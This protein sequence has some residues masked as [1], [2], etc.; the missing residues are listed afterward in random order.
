MRDHPLIQGP[1]DS[2]IVLQDFDVPLDLEDRYAQRL[3]AYLQVNMIY[4]YLRWSSSCRFSLCF[5]F[6]E[7]KGNEKLLVSF[8]H[9]AGFHY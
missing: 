2:R 7:K 4:P 3:T 9:P 8:I 6:L 1:P 5:V